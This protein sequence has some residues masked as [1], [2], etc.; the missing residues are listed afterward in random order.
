MAAG[1]ARFAGPVRIL[2][3]ERDRTAQAFLAA[4]DA[5][6]SAARALRRRE[7]RVRRSPDARD[8]LLAPSCSALR[9]A[10]EQARQLD[11]GRPAELADRAQLGEAVAGIGQH[12]SRRAPSSTGCS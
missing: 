9:L 10:D 12:P 8:W 6:R 2:L 5:E 7:P 4:W 1:L 3:A 11:M